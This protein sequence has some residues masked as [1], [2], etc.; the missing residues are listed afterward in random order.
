MN[1]RTQYL[2]HV[3][4]DR[5][6]SLLGKFPTIPRRCVTA[7]A[8][9]LVLNAPYLWDGYM[10]DIALKSLGAGVYEVTRKETHS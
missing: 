9:S 6:V 1:T 5:I 2:I 8:R 4:R 10:F 3:E 7:I